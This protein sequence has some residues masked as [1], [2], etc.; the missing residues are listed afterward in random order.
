MAAPIYGTTRAGILGHLARWAAAGSVLPGYESID[1]GGKILRDVGAEVAVALQRAGHGLSP[2][3][4]T[5]SVAYDYLTALIEERCAVMF[6]ESNGLVEPGALDDVKRRNEAK[7]ADIRNGNE[8]GSL[9]STDNTRNAVFKT[10]DVTR[11]TID[12]RRFR[13]GDPM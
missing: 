9:T 7:L 8:F 2:T 11:A 5:D 3:I 12:A 1:T 10:G 4:V 6:A 13:H